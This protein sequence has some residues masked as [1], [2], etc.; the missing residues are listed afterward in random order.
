MI[1]FAFDYVPANRL[2]D[3]VALAGADPEGVRLLAGGTWVIPEMLEGRSHPRTVI[4]LGRAGLD[5]IV[6]DGERVRVGPLATYTD[7]L[8][9]DAI[10]R[11]APLLRMIAAGITGG[12][13]IRNRGTIGGAA[14]QARPASDVPAGLAL[15]DASFEIAGASGRR[16]VAAEDFFIGAYRTALAAGEVLAEIV[17]PAAAS[18]HYFGYYKLKIAEGSW[19]IATAAVRLELGAWG[20]VV[21]VAIALGGVS[22][23]PIRLAQS[24]DWRLPLQADVLAALGADCQNALEDQWSDELATGA[25]RKRVIGVVAVRAARAAEAAALGEALAGAG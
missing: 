22:A 2:E 10:S 14:C 4:D 25:Y 8:E 13:Q 23:R 1:P 17:I 5:F 24:I 18:R 6:A 21:S 9:S 11:Q 3:A 16:S 7:I 20:N 15:A 12:R 19:P